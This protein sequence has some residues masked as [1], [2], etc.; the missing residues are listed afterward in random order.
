MLCSYH[1]IIITKNKEGDGKLLEVMD[2][3]MV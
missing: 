2:L 1:K 3:F